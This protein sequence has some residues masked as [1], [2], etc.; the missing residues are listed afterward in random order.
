MKADTYPSGS[1]LFHFFLKSKA[2]S[3][4][5][6]AVLFFLCFSDQVFSTRILGFNFRWGQILLLLLAW[7]S[8]T[9]LIAD[10]RKGSLEGNNRLR[11]LFYW[12]PFFL[13]YGLAA[14]N[15]TSPFLTGIK[16]CWGIFN[17]GC[18]LLVVLNPQWDLWTKNAF[19]RGFQWGIGLVAGIIWVQLLASCWFG[20]SQAGNIHDQISQRVTISFPHFVLLL[21]FG[22]PIGTFDNINLF[23]PCAFY[24]EPSYAGCALSFAL[25]LLLILDEQE[26]SARKGWLPGFILA[27][28]FLVSSRSGILSAFL[29][30]SLA[31][32]YFLLQNQKTFLKTIG[33]C[34]GV[35]FLLV[36][37]FCAT[38]HARKFVHYIF[39][40][41]GIESV[42][43]FNNIGTSEGGR[44]AN[45]IQSLKIC[46][47]HPFLGNGIYAGSGVGGNG[48]G[49]LAMNTWLE[50]GLESGAFGVLTFLGALLASMRWA[51]KGGFFPG[52]KFW[53]FAAWTSHL[54]LNLN[55]T[56]TF[57]RLDYWL[58][59]YFSIYLLIRSGLKKF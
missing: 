12:A 32:F 56:Q 33:K 51:L 50:I 59:F 30:L 10:V 20:I 1:S 36:L 22:Q 39:F 11:L 8:L 58:I 28:V 55:L 35:G 5:L 9:R 38:P 3:T 47:L 14:L 4:F 16:G 17:I 53:A 37:M 27:T 2:I 25:P 44:F 52:E 57:P 18:A 29:S 34:L 19:L 6:F 7:P 54:A 48:L 40:P 26:G 15:S 13:I 45:I 41:L 46:K 42:S 24:Y 43:R 49:Q 31:S 23:R 21:G